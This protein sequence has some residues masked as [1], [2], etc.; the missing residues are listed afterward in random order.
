MLISER[1]GGGE[2]GGEAKDITRAIRKEM[3]AIGFGLGVTSD[4]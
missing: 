1:R 3:I 4:E 2:G